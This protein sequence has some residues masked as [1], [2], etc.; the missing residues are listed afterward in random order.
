MNK[1]LILMLFLAT[2]L[3]ATEDKMNICFVT[4]NS[5]EEKEVFKDKL[6]K[7]T[8]KGKF[9]FHELVPFGEKEDDWFENACQNNIRCDV[10]VIS[11]HFGGSFFGKSGFELTSDELEQRSCSADCKNI[12]EAPKEVFLLGCNTLAGKEE[13]N[14]SAAEYM[15]VLVADDIPVD[16]AARRVEERYGVIGSSFQS[17]MRRSFRNVPHL[18]GFHSISPSGKNIE[19]LLVKYHSDIPNYYDHLMKVEVERALALKGS[20]EQWNKKNRELASALKIT[21]FT[22]A[23]GILMPCQDIDNLSVDDPIYEV[24]HNICK[25]KNE[26]L[27]L[28]ERTNHL[29]ELL[30]RDDVGLYIPTISDFLDDFGDKD[31]KQKI[32]EFI[33]KNE[34]IKNSL[35]SY[36]E[37]S[38]S[39]FGKLQVAKALMKLK[40][41]GYDNFQKI[42][43]EV[44]L[45]YLKVPVSTQSKDALCSY[46]LYDE[47]EDSEG[48]DDSEE[49][50]N[51]GRRKLNISYEDLDPKFF[52]DQNAINTLICLQFVDENIY[53]NLK[54]ATGDKK[55][56][57]DFRFLA[58]AT[59]GDISKD[60]KEDAVPYLKNKLKN[61]DKNERLA[62]L[63]A[64]ARLNH[65]DEDFIRHLKLSLKDKRQISIGGY[66]ISSSDLMT[67]AFYGAKFDSFDQYKEVLGLITTYNQ[68]TFEEHSY[69]FGRELAKFSK[70]QVDEVLK[71]LKHVTRDFVNSYLFEL[72]KLD[73]QL[74]IDHLD[75]LLSKAKFNP[76]D[77]LEFNT[78]VKLSESDNDKLYEVLSKHK[79]L[80]KKFIENSYF[81]LPMYRELEKKSKNTEVWTKSIPHPASVKFYFNNKD[82]WTKGRDDMIFNLGNGGYSE[83]YPQSISLELFEKVIEAGNK[84]ESR[85]PVNYGVWAIKNAQDELKFFE[86]LKNNLAN[87]SNILYPGLKA[88]LPNPTTDKIF[89]TSTLEFIYERFKSGDDQ[90]MWEYVD[91]INGYY[92]ERKDKLTK[93]ELA[94]IEKIKKLKQEDKIIWKLNF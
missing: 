57:S 23:S 90:Y 75:L 87:K 72:S 21:N 89:T 36:L 47:F 85:Y 6:S 66:P 61:G 53:K 38:K 64:L 49:S 55:K 15:D 65:F 41:L 54:S 60:Y 51:Y 26:E 67:S 34:A 20:F 74:D 69:T 17:I 5:S 70:E 1:S 28:S 88:Y 22:Q 19:N 73:K 44:I 56:S 25:L 81:E 68:K 42:E 14:R 59:L 93:D 30:Q 16:V 82:L 92:K 80:I 18:Y 46:D 62:S 83:I 35:L 4:I 71:G 24:T 48:K 50:Y 39:A 11:G 2:K 12:M 10:L 33:Q 86:I 37:R 7:G 9:N 29:I 58:L 52:E 3:W 78:T 79:V 40:V 94:V 32:Y 91:Y 63:Y 27:D 84:S 31:E 8:N 13:D 45:G 76:Q 77:S 43:K